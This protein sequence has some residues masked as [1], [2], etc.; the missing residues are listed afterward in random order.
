MKK[1]CH[2]WTQWNE[3]NNAV[4]EKRMA[5]N[6]FSMISKLI[7]EFQKIF[8]KEFP[9][10]YDLNSSKNYLRNHIKLNSLTQNYEIL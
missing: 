1:E 10:F 6:I 8:L 4:R 3:P 2:L 5:K 7:T 9:C